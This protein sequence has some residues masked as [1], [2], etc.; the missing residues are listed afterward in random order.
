MKK[1][2]A[3]PITRTYII[4]AW[5]RIIKNYVNEDLPRVCRK[6]SLRAVQFTRTVG[7]KINL[8][9]EKISSRGLT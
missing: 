9:A 4:R 3:W 2:V 6:K 7:Y 5:F 1:F 8:Q